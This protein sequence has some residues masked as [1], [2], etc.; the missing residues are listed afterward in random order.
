[1]KCLSLLCAWTLVLLPAAVAATQIPANGLV[2]IVN[3]EAITWKDVEQEA[4]LTIESKLSLYSNRPAQLQ[5]E[6]EKARKEA[7]EILVERKLILNEF[8]SAGYN[9]P[10][11]FID[12]RVRARLRERWGGDR[13]AMTRDLAARGMTFERLRQ[14]ERE[15]FIVAIMRSKNVSQEVVTSPFRIEKYYADNIDKYKVGDQVKLR[16]IM[17]NKPKTGSP[18]PA[19]KRAEEILAK[20]DQ[21]AS[22][23]EMAGV[24]SEDTYRSQG[25]NRGWVE[26]AREHYVKELEDAI[27]S[28]KPGQRSGIIEAG[29]AYWIILVEDTK[30][31]YTRSLPEVRTEIEQELL[32]QERTRLEKQWIDRLKAKS[33]VRYF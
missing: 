25:G 13:A 11:S 16:T 14:Q 24:Y 21:G 31:N 2:A 17:I 29:P 20:L 9:L 26:L 27:R 7:I 23:A 32:T 19:R 28:L 10:E 5:A 12:D 4:S 8:K 18:E 1:M 33:F 6:I 22:F 30:L 15:R 3:D